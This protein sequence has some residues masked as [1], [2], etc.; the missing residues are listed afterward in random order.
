MLVV[1]MGD[2]ELPALAT[3]C[4]LTVGQVRG[5]VAQYGLDEATLHAEAEKLRR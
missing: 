4:C 1:L 3:R 2:H 5:L